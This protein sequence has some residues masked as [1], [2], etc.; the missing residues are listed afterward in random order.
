MNHVWE[1]NIYV[2]RHSTFY[3]LDHINWGS[4]NKREWW[5]HSQILNTWTSVKALHLFTTSELSGMIYETEEDDGPI[6]AMQMIAESLRTKAPF[7]N[8]NKAPTPNNLAC[9]WNGQ[10]KKVATFLETYEWHEF[11]FVS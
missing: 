2:M 7:W 3:Y 5:S 4:L 1:W 10:N 6:E 8:V 11:A 9:L